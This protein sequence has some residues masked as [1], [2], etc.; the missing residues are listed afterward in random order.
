MLSPK[1][2]ALRIVPT[3]VPN[4]QIT[5]AILDFNCGSAH[6]SRR[7]QNPERCVRVEVV[8]EQIASLRAYPGYPML[9]LWEN[10]LRIVLNRSPNAQIT[11]TL[12]GFNCVSSAHVS[13][14]FPA[15]HAACTAYMNREVCGIL[16]RIWS[17]E[18]AFA[19]R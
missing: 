10:T 17:S 18:R 8:L 12:L 5:S 11:P 6:A 7:F 19:N 13:R 15:G 3:L 9:S 4:A 2:N 1:E 14:R 16:Q